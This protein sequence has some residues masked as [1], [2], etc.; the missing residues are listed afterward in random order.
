M[1]KYGP[2]IVNAHYHMILPCLVA[3]ST[4]FITSSSKL[5]ILNKYS[6]KI[7]CKQK[8]KIKHACIL[9]N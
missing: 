6:V 4:L 5:K 7:W 8:I 3:S 9:V 2:F 1:G